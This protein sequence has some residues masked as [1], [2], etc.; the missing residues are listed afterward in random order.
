MKR[1]AVKRLV[2]LTV[3]V[4]MLCIGFT[5]NA[6]PKEMKDGNVF[7]AEHYKKYEDVVSVYG[8]S[9]ASLYKHYIQYG[10]TENREA[11]AAPD[12]SI[13]DSEY[14]AKNNP[15][16]VAVYGTGSNS[17]YQHYLSHGKAE[18][19]KGT[20]TDTV[21]AVVSSATTEPE[22]TQE[23]V[24]ESKPTETPAPANNSVTSEEAKLIA[25]TF[26]TQLVSTMPNNVLAFF[27]AN[28]DFTF[29]TN[30]LTELFYWAVD[31]YTTT[32]RSPLTDAENIALANDIKFNGGAKIPNKIY[33]VK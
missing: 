3:V 20:A 7:D 21:A 17:L 12:K 22:Q 18:G 5:V 19:R 4:N 26:M 14:Y 2:T 15:D 33:Y 23:P 29:D 24:K 27:D 1:K 9:E 30:E 25:G 10:I 8:T 13:F 31:N 16:V 11:V 32:K 6:Q 28:G